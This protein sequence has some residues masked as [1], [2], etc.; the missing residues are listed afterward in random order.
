MFRARGAIINYAQS[1]Q[2]GMVGGR[3][4]YS[5][6]S[7]VTGDDVTPD[8]QAVETLA[9]LEEE[10]MTR[11]VRDWLFQHS[12]DPLDHEI[13][14]YRFG[15]NGYPQL[16]LREISARVRRPF[17]TV[18]R[19]IEKSLAAMSTLADKSGYLGENEDNT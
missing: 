18:R 7:E 4:A 10:E 12:D 2:T 3:D 19:R 8:D 15:L 9:E 11:T 16:T 14:C 1:E 5:P 13:V 17:I 6:T